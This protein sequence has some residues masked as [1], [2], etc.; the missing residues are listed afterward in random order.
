M[1][2]P[3]GKYAGTLDI[4]QNN[5]DRLTVFSKKYFLNAIAPAHRE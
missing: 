4:C 5:R 3:S 2:L 1:T